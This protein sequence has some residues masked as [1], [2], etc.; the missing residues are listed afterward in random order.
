MDALKRKLGPLPLWQWVLIG[1]VLGGGVLLWRRG[2]PAAA[3]A[4]GA[5]PS[6]AQYQPI[7]P[8][9]GLPYAGG[10]T[11]SPGGDE[12][13][14]QGPFGDLTGIQ[15]Q[16]D[17]ILGALSDIQPGADVETDHAAVAEQTGTGPAR[18]KPGPLARAKA[19]VTS[20]RVGPVN[21]A[22]LR[23]AGYTDA[24]IN[25]H[26]R[27]RT[28]LAKPY[29]KQHP[30]RKPPK[31]QPAHSPGHRETSHG[32]GKRTRSSSAPH[33][34]RQHGHVQP[35][36]HERHEPIKHPSATHPAVHSPAAP[37]PHHKKKKR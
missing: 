27:H 31:H 18:R 16:L 32:G 10:V 33:N 37:A 1:A 7:D 25:Y 35:P 3:A 23:A 24:Q 26:I 20:G 5:V 14:P 13:P 15:D 19:A 30:G 4:A 34:P 8:T 17:A 6:D 22:R 11:T 9:T 29:A 2:H 36:A 12:P 28:P 21:R